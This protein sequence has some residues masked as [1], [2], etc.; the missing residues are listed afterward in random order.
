M[1]GIRTQRI[2]DRFARLPPSL[3]Q[4]AH[5]L[6]AEEAELEQ[7][8][9]AREL[10]I[11]LLL[12]QVPNANR[13]VAERAYDQSNEDVE[14]ALEVVRDVVAQVEQFVLYAWWPTNPR[15]PPTHVPPSGEHM[16]SYE[17]LGLNTHIRGTRPPELS[18]TEILN[19][20]AL[21]EVSR[22]DFPN[23][24]SPGSRYI[25]NERMS[26]LAILVSIMDLVEDIDPAMVP[27]APVLASM[28][29]ICAEGNMTRAALGFR[30]PSAVARCKTAIL[31]GDFP[32]PGYYPNYNNMASLAETFASRQRQLQVRRSPAGERIPAV[33]IGDAYTDR[34]ATDA[35]VGPVVERP[36]VVIQE[37]DEDEEEEEEERDEEE[38][39]R[40]RDRAP[41]TSAELT[42][43]RMMMEQERQQMEEEVA[44]NNGPLGMRSEPQPDIGRTQDLEMVATHASVEGS[45]LPPDLIALAYDRNDG[46][47]VN[48]IMNLTEPIFRRQLERELGERS[49]T[50]MYRRASSAYDTELVRVRDDSDR[51]RLGKSARVR[52][53]AL[54]CYRGHLKKCMEELEER[55]ASGDIDEGTY[56]ERADDLMRNYNLTTPTTV[57]PMLRRSLAIP[58]AD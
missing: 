28:F 42:R 8:S 14:R 46:D 6:E 51:P 40:A 36:D 49:T 19:Q 26:D 17:A 24:T 23:A 44:T 7:L 32:H 15:N 57:L 18:A 5:W 12:N 4:A 16:R 52:V 3:T 39:A 56:K 25:P 10:D 29:Y 37:R 41:L 9:A 55:V 35:I 20:L 45:R 22:A 30:S 1:P 21:L 54:A 43:F 13:D 50:N 2:S 38:E 58:N 47:I 34:E 11:Q 33:S 31:N 53:A 48:A 27:I